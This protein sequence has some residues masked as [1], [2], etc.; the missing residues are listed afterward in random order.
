MACT[1]VV[2]SL[3]Y[4]GVSA[5]V[6]N[7]PGN[8]ELSCLSN[9]IVF[10]GFCKAVA[11]AYVCMCVCVC[12]WHGFIS[13]PTNALDLEQDLRSDLHSLQAVLK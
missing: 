4:S 13:T 9:P 2:S 12:V 3:S 11:R 7:S 5:M 10:D 1:T 8:H 6:L